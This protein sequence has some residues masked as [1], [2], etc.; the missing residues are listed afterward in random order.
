MK[1]KI[2][3]LFSISFID[4]IYKMLVYKDFFRVSFPFIMKWYIK[5]TRKKQQRTITQIRKRTVEYGDKFKITVAFFLQSPSVWKYDALYWIFEKSNRF[6]P[7]V[8]ICPFNVHLNYSNRERLR[9]MQEAEN[10]VQQKGYKYISSYNEEKKHWVNIRK[11]INPDIVFFAKPY[12]DTLPQY[13]I[14]KFRDKITC[15]Y[16]YGIEILNETTKI[17]SNLPLHNLLYHYFVETEINKNIIQKNSIVKG[18]NVLVSSFLGMENMIKNDYVPVN[19]WKKQDREKKRVIWSPHH[20]IDYLFNFSNFLM[21][22][23]VML[24]F[25]RKYKDKIQFAFKPHPVLKF[26][27][28]NLWGE[29]KT[30]KYYDLWR[31]MPN[32]QIAE[33]EYVDL[34]FTSDAMIHDSCAFTVEYL[35]SMKPTLF[36]AKRKNMETEFNELGKLAYFLHYHAFSEQDIDNFLQC[37]VLDGKD[38]M[39]NDRKYF[40]EKYLL[41]QN[42]IFPSEMIF[43]T[44]NQEL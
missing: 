7:I 8:I 3:M 5:N 42:G 6:S 33:G 39:F 15:Y 20:T 36:T 27:L 31:T 21:Y 10:F 41:P 43:N 24:E 26:K 22:S 38:T 4:V 18:E 11:V 14:Y 1:N 28:L 23:E 34:F 25:A 19:V 37:V 16:P 9:V 44:L 17:T 2:K 35:F 12:K 32:T 13:Y 40:Y 30:E 29:E